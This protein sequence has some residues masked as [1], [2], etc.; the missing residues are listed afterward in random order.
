M[1]TAYSPKVVEHPLNGQF[2]D[3][4]P[5]STGIGGILRRVAVKHNHRAGFATRRHLAHV[6]IAHTDMMLHD[7][8]HLFTVFMWKSFLRPSRRW[9]GLYCTR[10]R[11]GSKNKMTRP[12]AQRHT[13]DRTNVT[14][15]LML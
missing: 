11:Y 8:A 9:Q 12:H 2:D 5:S 10:E 6:S 15:V 4:W 1:L 7:S 13:I 3:F 14:L